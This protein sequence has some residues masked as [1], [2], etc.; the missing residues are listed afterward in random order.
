MTV[1]STLVALHDTFCTACRCLVLSYVFR[2]VQYPLFRD[3]SFVGQAH[4]MMLN[5][6]YDVALEFREKVALDDIREKNRK[7]NNLT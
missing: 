4:V 1:V 6:R 3:V 5:S 2:D 7:K